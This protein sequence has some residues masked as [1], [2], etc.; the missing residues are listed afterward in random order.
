VVAVSHRAAA[1]LH[2]LWSLP[3]EMVE[4]TVPA[5]ESP[6]LA[7]VTVHRIAD[8]T[9]RWITTIDGIDVTSPARLIVDLGAVLPLGSVA[10]VFDRA[11]ARGVVSVAEVRSVIRAVARRG[12][13]GVGIGR[14]LVA[15]RSETKR[16]SVLERRMAA[17]IRRFGL[18]HPVPEHTV[19]DEHGQF[20]ARVDFA[21]PELR[22]A[23]EVD[24]FAAHSARPAFDHDR[25]RQNDLVDHGWVV[26]RFTWNDIE[27]HPARVA[28]RIR[29]RHTTILR[30]L[31][32]TT[33]A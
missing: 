14:V 2:G 9:P 26:H 33:A 12:R 28:V 4:I 7:G 18:P 25:V 5:D 20:V 11:L 27:R 17:L 13:A 23:I 8:L 29:A 19:L 32:P 21:Y 6:D 15:E 1:G 3:D 31:E 24:G 30:T 22:Y 10:R 16:G